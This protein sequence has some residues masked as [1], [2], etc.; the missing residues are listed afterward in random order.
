MKPNASFSLPFPFIYKVICKVSMFNWLIPTYLH[1]YWSKCWVHVMFIH[2][3]QPKVTLHMLSIFWTDLCN[4]RVALPLGRCTLLPK[5]H[6]V[7]A[8]ANARVLLAHARWPWKR[9]IWTKVPLWHL[10]PYV[11]AFQLIKKHPN[12]RSITPDMPILV[13][14]VQCARTESDLWLV[15]FLDQPSGPI[16]VLAKT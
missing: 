12:Q 16:Q 15:R 2:K 5:Q 6:S 13:Q 4:A 7:P 10:C 9:R 14:T 1:S 11:L 3:I 8:G